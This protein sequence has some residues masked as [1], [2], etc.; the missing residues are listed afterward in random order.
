MN[1]F[2]ASFDLER[3]RRDSTFRSMRAALVGMRWYAT[4]ETLKLKD[5]HFSA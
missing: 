4:F 5:L 1:K 3:R 2:N